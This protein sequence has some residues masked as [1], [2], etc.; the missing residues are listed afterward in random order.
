ME[1]AKNKKQGEGKSIMSN[2]YTYGLTIKNLGFLFNEIE[3]IKKRSQNKDNT[4]LL[5][6]WMSGKAII[7]HS[8]IPLKKAQLCGIK[9]DFITICL[10]EYILTSQDIANK[11]AEIMAY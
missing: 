2:V 6:N 5:Y 9:Y 1:K 8:L 10:I 3:Q 7:Y 11:I 4:W